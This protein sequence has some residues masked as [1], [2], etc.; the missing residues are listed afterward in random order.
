MNSTGQSRNGRN[1]SKAVVICIPRT[2]KSTMTSASDSRRKDW[3]CPWWTVMLAAANMWRMTSSAPIAEDF[4]SWIGQAEKTRWT[5]LARLPLRVRPRAC[6]R[7][8]LPLFCAWVA[9][10]DKISSSAGQSDALDWAVNLF[11]TPLK[12]TQCGQLVCLPPA[13]C[14]SP[15]FPLQGRSVT[16]TAGPEKDNYNLASPRSLA[17]SLSRTPSTP[18]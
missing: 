10:S 15:I 16:V 11:S 9:P 6:E 7:L 17:R 5:S 18:T 8:D 4:A 12:K 1:G 14:P 2:P 13:C 3:R